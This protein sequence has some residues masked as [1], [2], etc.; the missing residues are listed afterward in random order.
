MAVNVTIPRSV[1]QLWLVASGVGFRQCT[2]CP[3]MIVG[4]IQV[5]VCL[6]GPGG[7]AQ[8]RFVLKRLC[9][10][11]ECAD[12]YCFPPEC[13][14]CINPVPGCLYICAYFDVAAA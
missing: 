2:T 7:A 6:L 11:S 10:I 14:D 5:T 3:N 12:D 13:Q 4:V 1:W 8:V 9:F